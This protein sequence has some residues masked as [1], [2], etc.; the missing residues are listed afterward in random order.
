MASAA[1][2]DA[3]VPRTR[4]PRSG[5]SL[6]TLLLLLLS[7]A[8]ES[9][10]DRLEFWG[11]G[12]EGEVVAEMIPE[13]ERRNPGINVVV[14]QIPWTA[15]HEKLLTA[16][17]GDS[18]PDMAQMGNTWV[19]EFNAI[20]AL[21]DLTP[22]AA[23]STTIDQSDYF[24]GIWATNVVE[25]KLYGIPWYVDA[26]VLFY[27]SDIL[28]SVGFPQGPRTWS[29]WVQSMERIQSQRKARFGILLPTTEWEPVV[30][31]ALTNGATILT[32]DGTRGAFRQ[33]EFAEAFAFYID[34]YRRGF[35]PALS[36]T[37]IANLYQQFAQGDFAM[38]ISGPWN[39]GEFKRR[40]PENM[41][42]KWATAPLPARDAST[43][44]GISMAGGSSL[45]IFRAS[46]NKAAAR[47][48]IEFLS[49]PAQQAR[50]Y[51][52]TGDLPARRSAWRSGS[53]AEE[54]RLS[55]FREQL[56]RVAPLP[57]VPEW[58]QI[59]TAIFDRGEA[60]ARGTISNEA[61]LTALD[62]KADE[63]L[64]KRRWMMSRK[65]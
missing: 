44:T 30:N 2:E 18:T 3:R 40:L 56:E 15:A 35:A 24:P 49:E 33:K 60:A 45:V 48:L 58:E 61:A 37:Q 4:R 22:F 41:Q 62:A 21:E 20:H 52:T 63:L 8:G 26:R 12:R 64:E 14:Q 31:M 53:L 65:P 55:A 59:A 13:F 7:C 28:A 43:P 27:R 38:Y 25:G 47:K 1:G 5:P 11:L 9:A 6:L 36:N 19:P 57:K 50:F 32:P 34:M 46:P 51:E 29:E 10:T 23:S 39:V 42:D 16:F 54:P 17:V